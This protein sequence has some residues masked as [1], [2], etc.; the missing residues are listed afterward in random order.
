MSQGQQSKKP[1]FQEFVEANK[2]LLQCYRKV[3]VDD[4]K[5]MSGA[6]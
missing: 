6:G 3:S 4:Y 2:G 5:K 1:I